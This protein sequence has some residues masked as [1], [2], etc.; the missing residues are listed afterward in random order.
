[1]PT[2]NLTLP[3]ITQ[4]QKV[5]ISISHSPKVIQP[6][7]K[8]LSLKTNHKW[9][10]CIQEHNE[11]NHSPGP[12]L[13]SWE[14][15]LLLRRKPCSKANFLTF[16]SLTVLSVSISFIFVS[17]SGVWSTNLQH[18]STIAATAC[19]K[20]KKTHSESSFYS[21]NI[22]FWI[23][24]LPWPFTENTKIAS[25]KNVSSCVP[26][27]QGWNGYRAIHLTLYTCIWLSG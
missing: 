25:I 23:K 27:Y 1:M 10:L 20:Q 19:I 18:S 14:K 7:V 5:V 12:L 6:H 2:K 26:K 22:I 15:V 3:E 13:F 24:P 4:C 9:V 8:L 11:S 17:R 21:K 16:P